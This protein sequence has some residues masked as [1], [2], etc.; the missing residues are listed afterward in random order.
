MGVPAAGSGAP[1]RGGAGDDLAMGQT[2][3]IFGNQGRS[4]GVAPATITG[5]ARLGIGGCHGWTPPMPQARDRQH[6]QAWAPSW[7]ACSGVSRPAASRAPVMRG[8]SSTA[9]VR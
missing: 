4:Q 9:W 7:E 3:Q 5:E 8:M 6:A 1:G 2:R